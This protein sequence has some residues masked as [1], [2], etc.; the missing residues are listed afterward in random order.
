M[1]DAAVVNPF[2]GLRPFE[3]G[4]AALFFGRD[5]QIGEA[6]DRLLQ[7]RLLT[8]VGVSGCGN[9]NLSIKEWREYTTLPYQRTCSEFPPGK[10]AK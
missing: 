4:D 3:A 9:R 8:V 6:L 5:E 2:P 10:G 1:I 7:R